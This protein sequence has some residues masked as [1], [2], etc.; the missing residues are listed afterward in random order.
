MVDIPNPAPLLYRI[1]TALRQ[2]PCTIEIIDCLP[3]DGRQWIRIR[4]DHFAPIQLFD[5]DFEWTLKGEKKPSNF[6]TP[7]VWVLSSHIKSSLLPGQSFEHPVDAHEISD[8]VIRCR[9]K[10]HH[11]RSKYPTQKDF[12]P[13]LC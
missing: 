9:I 7:L 3:H 4:N 13:I 6:H 5:I 1:W 8:E 12:K 10:V 11:N 2:N